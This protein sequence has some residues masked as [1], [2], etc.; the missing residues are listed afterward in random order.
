MT[1][2][3]TPSTVLIGRYRLD[4]LIGRGAMAEVWRAH[5][6]TRDWPVAVKVFAPLNADPSMRAR[7]AQEARTA[8]RVVHTNVVSVFDVGDHDGRPFLVMELLSG[9]SLADELAER[10]PLPLSEVRRL[11]GQ[12]AVGL[13]AA[14]RSGVIHRDVKPANLHVTDEGQLKVVDFGIARL[15]GEVEGRLT[16]VGTVVGT[17]AYMS[18]EQIIG[19]PGEA[20]ADLYALGCVAYEMLCG[21]PPFTGSAVELIQHHLNLAPEPPSRLRPDVPPELASLTLALLDKD[22]EARPTAGQLLSRLHSGRPV[23][24][25]VPTA[26]PRPTTVLESPPAPQGPSGQTAALAITGVAVVVLLLL[27]VFRPDQGTPMSQA[28]RPTAA[29]PTQASAAPA[30]A[31]PAPTPTPTPTSSPTP[32]PTRTTD[33]LS[34]WL[35]GLD[36]AVQAQVKQGGL[37]DDAAEGLRDRIAK[38]RHQ[39]DTKHVLKAILKARNDGDLSGRGPLIDYLTRSG[40]TFGRQ[41]GDD[42]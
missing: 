37:D 34:T 3:A 10:G 5:D 31:A 17:P 9:R 16:A 20:P 6:L 8:A 23:Q 26:V 7:F 18:P 33:K 22:P 40:L 36:R 39:R 27:L 13:D 2:S 25:T 30:S 1:G 32:A 19:R 4:L 14:H 11:L 28:A 12:A 41:G 42:D 24:P 35:L 38:A 21:R 15:A 29:P